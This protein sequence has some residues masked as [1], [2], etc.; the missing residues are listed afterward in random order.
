MNTKI[1]SVILMASIMG[2]AAGCWAD[3]ANAT[4]NKELHQYNKKTAKANQ[5]TKDDEIKAHQ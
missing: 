2:T 4:G 5:D 1:T 3:D